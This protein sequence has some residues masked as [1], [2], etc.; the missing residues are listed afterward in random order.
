MTAPLR[1]LIAEDNF[2][3]RLLAEEAFAELEGAVEVHFCGNGLQMLDCLRDAAPWTPDVVVLDINMPIMNG[4]ET[5]RVIRTEPALMHFPVVMLSSSRSPDDIA[6]S[7]DLCAASYL[8]KEQDFP[9]F[10]LQVGAFVEFW[11]NCRFSRAR[12]GLT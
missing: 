5:L 12:P 11:S 6:T 9:T 10:V 1:V 3:D 7:Y 8:V 2:G 4:F